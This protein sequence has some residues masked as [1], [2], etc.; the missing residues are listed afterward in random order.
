MAELVCTCTPAEVSPT[1]EIIPGPG[2]NA[3]NNGGG[4]WTITAQNALDWKT[5][6]TPNITNLTP[7]NW[8]NESEYLLVGK[9]L[10]LLMAV[11]FG[12][13]TSFPNTNTWRIDLPEG[14]I[15]WFDDYANPPLTSGH[16]IGEC[17]IFDASANE[18]WKGTVILDRTDPTHPLTVRFGDDAGATSPLL[19]RNVPI[20]GGFAQN[21]ELAIWIEKMEVM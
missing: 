14:S 3:T 9:T 10:S 12:S 17:T 15:P 21:D 16:Q 11:R 6:W 1:G 18:Y 4:N 7:G 8:I 19:T 20:T 2:I 5:T 13:T